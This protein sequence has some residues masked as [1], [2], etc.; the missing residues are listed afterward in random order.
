MRALVLVGGQ[1]T[2]LR[3][4]TY[5]IPKPM[6]PVA[7]RPI[8]AR[9][10]EWLGRHGVCEATL[11]LGYLPQP[12][13]DTFPSGEVAGVRLRY[14]VE[15]E[16]LDTAGAIRY[17]AAQSAM[18]DERIVVVNG[19]ILTDLDL[20]ALIAF[21]EARGACASIALTPVEDPS[22]YGVVDKAA[23]GEVLAFIEKPAPGAE[24]TNLINAG[25][26]VLEP[27]ALAMIAPE[28]RVSIER[29]TFPQLV[30]A[31]RLYAMES[32]AYWID[33]GTP[34]R[35]RQA[36]LDV[37]RGLRP[38]VVVPD[39][40]EL[41]PGLFL[42]E[43]AQLLGEAAGEVLLGAGAL[44]EKGASVTDST[45]G[46]RVVVASGATV[47]DAVVLA[48]AEIAK[49]AVVEAAV[50]GPGALVGAGA[51]VSGAIIGH[52]ATVE[53]GAELRGDPPS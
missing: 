9:I 50:I 34:E 29:E 49:G 23:D 47:R 27:E 43:G 7:G 40:T 8:I 4:L 52:G 48:D 20:G 15:S 19:D 2:R 32:D 5:D 24:P 35:Y 16:P 45:I 13:L 36:Q 37:L 21:H 6:L 53:P 41:R 10:L 46:E 30:A 12:F 38:D 17:A 1:G 44:V 25:T 39:A 22:A 51:L 26:Y 42:G 11:S 28:G 33:T 14:A 3:P 31:G 18:S